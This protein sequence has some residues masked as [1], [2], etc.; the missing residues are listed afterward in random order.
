[1]DCK[2]KTI[3]PEAYEAFDKTNSCPHFS[4]RSCRM[5]ACT[6]HLAIKQMYTVVDA[7]RNVEC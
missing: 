2:I 6:F 5:D 4:L 1:M 7:N 3:K